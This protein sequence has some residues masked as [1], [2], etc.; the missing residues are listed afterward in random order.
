VGKI[1]PKSET[2]LAPEERLL[3]AIFGEKAADVKDTSLKVPSGT[4][5]IVMDVKVS[6]KD[7]KPVKGSS[8]KG[9]KQII[10]D[11][12]KKLAD[13]HEQLTEA[14]S[15]ILLGEKIPL[16][17]VNS[18]TGE[19]IIPSNRKITKTLLRKLAA[20]YDRIEIDPSP[21]RNK[22]NEILDSFRKRFD[23][24]RMA[25]D[26]E[27]QR[28]EAGVDVDPG[29][30]KN[31]KIYIASKRK[32]SVGDK[33][34]GR[35][36]NKGVV[37]KI[38]PEEDMPFLKDG[39]PVDICLNPLGVPSRMNVGQ[40]LETH[41]GWAAKILD[42]RF[43][44]PVFDG[45]NEKDIRDYLMQAAQKQ[46]DA[47]EPA[48]VGENGKTYLYDGQTGERFDQEIVVGYIYMLKLGHLVADKIH[49]RA[50][51]P[52]SLVTQQPLGGKAQY[53]G[54]RFG[55]MEV[56][57]MEAYGA[58]YTLQELLTVKSDDVQG[59]TRIYENIVKGDNT[60]DAGI[61][62]SFNVLVKEMESLCL[63][64]KVGYSNPSMDRSETDDTLAA[65]AS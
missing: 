33:M 42:L 28:I 5:G 24:M 6:T 23:D 56:W 49:A 53:G 34:A 1:T 32:L 60:L 52:Y 3:R 27:L 15:N 11:H 40:L 30:V 31:V 64:V 45:I 18:E 39:T 10:D 51:G 13:L 54:Q 19:I 25:H 17:V 22:I 21:I 44:T 12:K 47:N 20:V 50:V 9:E 8:K 4:Y 38:V 65:L 35:H 14:L 7:E 41:L 61:P 59:R 48:L 62:E 58:A 43:A 29:L 46:K 26:D 55:E 57:A 63:E 16:D 37:A 2:E 36:G